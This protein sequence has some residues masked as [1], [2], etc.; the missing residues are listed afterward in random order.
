MSSPA[1]VATQIKQ[2]LEAALADPSKFQKSTLNKEEL[3]ILRTFFG[4]KEKAH[5]KFVHLYNVAVCL[6]C[7]A[8]CIEDVITFHN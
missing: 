5:N 2:L 7:V 6:S 1:K 4:V 8:V 3:S